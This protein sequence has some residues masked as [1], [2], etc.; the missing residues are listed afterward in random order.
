M[1]RAK[2]VS[3]LRS[4]TALF[5]TLSLIATAGAEETYKPFVSAAP[6]GTTVAEASAAVVEKLKAAGLE[7][8]GQYQPYAD[9]SATVIGVTSA[10]MREAAA[11][12]AFGGFG[13]VLRVAV[14]DNKGAIEVSYV[15]PDYVARAYHIGGLDGIAAQ[16]RGVLGG[17]ASFGAKG[18]SAAELEK[19]HYMMFM[20]AFTD[21]EIIAEFGSNEEAVAKVAQ[22]LADPQ[23]D[24]S[25]VWQVK[26]NDNQTVFGVR[27]H[28]G[29]WQG[30]M[31][32][33]MG[34]IDVDTPRSTASLP[35]EML[36]T[37]NV[38]AYL[39]GKYRIA[40]MFPDLSMGTFMQI[41]DIPDNMAESAEKLAKLALG[42]QA[43]AGETKSAIPSF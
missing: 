3:L 26:I 14:T 22:A 18:L 20:P 19:Y 41:S 35:W 6:A 8:V 12:H 37:G 21:T 42:K 11:R 13:A 16:M 32:E 4:L 36:V 30:R 28:R 24:M 33:I 27:L 29:K 15:N 7:V 39:P 34:K 9:G 5:F 38:L 25:A 2:V 43:V 31:K 23:S 1:D 40:V 10:A 17:G